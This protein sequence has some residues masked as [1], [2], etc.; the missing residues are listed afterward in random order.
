MRV[1]FTGVSIESRGTA[2]RGASAA[3]RPLVRHATASRRP[4][5]GSRSSTRHL[6]DLFGDSVDGS[7]AS[8]SHRSWSMRGGLR[9]WEKMTH[10][11]GDSRPRLLVPLLFPSSTGRPARGSRAEKLWSRRPALHAIIAAYHLLPTQ[12]FRQGNG[13]PSSASQTSRYS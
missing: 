2:V 8:L 6:A 7:G 3:P 13:I 5:S 10:A 1:I 9:G 4:G 12:G 11:S